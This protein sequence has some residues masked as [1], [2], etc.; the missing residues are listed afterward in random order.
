MAKSSNGNVRMV[1]TEEKILANIE[2][3][4]K[5]I[6]PNSKKRIVKLEED[7]YF[8]DLIASIKSYLEEYPKQ[9][10]F[11]RDVYDA[12][13]DLVE[14]AT[15]QFEENTKKIEELIRQRESNIALASELKEVLKAVEAKETNWKKK[16]QDLS[17]KLPEDVID[18]LGVIGRAKSKK[19]QTY[20]DSLNLINTKVSNLESN[21]FIEVDMERIE[22]KSKALSYI[23]IE[24]AE[25]LKDIENI[26]EVK[27]SNKENEESNVQYN[28]ENQ[29]N[30]ENTEYIED[31]RVEVKPSLWE[32]IKNMKLV[33]GIRY[34]MKIKV[35][36][37][38]PEMPELPSGSDR[39]D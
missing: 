17:E 11:P 36:L 38:L 19:T 9:D 14:Y 4:K 37:E 23:G 5:M 13:Y 12:A 27:N 28:A 2:K 30:Q 3:V 33:R 22:D 7:S 34:I 39:K 25:S 29:E 15:T 8:L 18:T 20:L 31:T 21:L 16:V 6:N 24:I 1:I 35:V 10:V 26:E 32:R